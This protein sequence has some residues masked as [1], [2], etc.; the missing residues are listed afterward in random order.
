MLHVQ[1]IDHVDVFIHMGEK[2]RTQRLW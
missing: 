1:I 2:A